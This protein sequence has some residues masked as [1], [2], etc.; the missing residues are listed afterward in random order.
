M[1]LP[2]RRSAAF[3]FGLL[4]AALAVLPAGQVD[5]CRYTVRDVAFVDLGSS[6]YRLV[7]FS[8]GEP[9]AALV[10]AR[11][12]VRDR[13]VDSNVVLELIDQQDSEHPAVALLETTDV[14]E[15][16][17]VVLV[18]PDERL[19]VL[20][21]GMTELDSA[22]L[23]TLVDSIIASPVRE[24]LLSRAFDVHSTMIV[25]EGG[26]AAENERIVAMAEQF[27]PQVRDALPLMPKP[28]DGPPHLI[29][30]TREQIAAE[31]I[32]LWSL[33]VDLEDDT[34]TQVAIL[35]GRAR[36]LGPVLR[37]PGDDARKFERSLAVVGQDCECGLD[38]SWMQ[39]DM[40]PHI[41]D[42]ERERVAMARLRFDPGSPEVKT[43][44][45][46][47]LTRGP[48]G[49]QALAESDIVF[50][51]IGYQEIE[52]DA[53]ED[54]AVASRDVEVP[55]A[56]EASSGSSAPGTIADGTVAEETIAAAVDAHSADGVDDVEQ[57]LGASESAAVPF[58]FGIISLVVGALV[59][60]ALVGGGAVLMFSGRETSS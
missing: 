41:W 48:G 18:S 36:K 24:D 1:P 30:L 14:R 22:K 42:E 9:D 13:L 38:R 19:L 39:G 46:Q 7:V 47:L 26:D 12:A 31:R 25:V 53:P 11:D 34:A 45:A 10:T 37:F 51:A 33:G 4:V 57:T 50:P 44:I 55:A 21:E 5:A 16:P 15:F 43:E 52:L 49:K 27:I 17:A 3:V 28:I 56:G 32:L 54:V 6:P 60:V 23:N 29:V 40:V 20:A 59:L 35:F 2:A 58:E 8:E